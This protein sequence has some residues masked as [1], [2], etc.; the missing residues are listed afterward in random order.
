[1]TYYTF[2]DIQSIS[3]IRQPLIENKKR[4]TLTN[5]K[6]VFLSHSHKD[7]D[8]VKD[9]MAFLLSIDIYVYV[10][11][12]D[13]TMPSVTSAETAEKIKGKIVD[14]ERFIVLLTENS[15]ESKWV[16]WELGFADGKKPIE[17]IAILPIKKNRYT[18]DSSFNGL[19]YMKL[20]PIISIGNA[21][22]RTSPAIF[23]PSRLKGSG[24]WLKEGWLNKEKV[25]F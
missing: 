21:N 23:P 11:W 19:E 4:S 16:P 5:K 25:I 22:S 10:D 9:V 2:S 8:I 24:K 1:M 3:T 6:T 7:A 17:N 18:Q 15:K 13:P 12:L 14:C 20:Y